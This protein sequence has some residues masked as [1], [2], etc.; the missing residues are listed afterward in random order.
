MAGFL[1]GLVNSTV[2]VTEPSPRARAGRAAL[3][4]LAYRGI[5]LSTGAMAVRNLVVLG[6]LGIV[7]E[8]VVYSRLLG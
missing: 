1:G 5:L 2:T 3:M 6:I 4:D 7:V 8:Q